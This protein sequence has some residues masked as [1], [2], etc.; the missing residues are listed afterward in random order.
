M[1]MEMSEKKTQVLDRGGIDKALTRIA[2]E[3]LE[4]SDNPDNLALIGIRTRGEFIATRL[5]GK[6]QNRE[7][8]YRVY[9]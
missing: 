6:S 5:A 4:Q 1:E 3:I 2:H 9:A 7:G 8:V